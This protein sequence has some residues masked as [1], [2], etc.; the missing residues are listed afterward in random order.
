MV[1]SY[2]SA[3]LYLDATFV[4]EVHTAA[5]NHAA[6]LPKS[7]PFLPNAYPSPQ[8]PANV[9]FGTLLNFPFSITC[10]GLPFFRVARATPRFSPRAS[11]QLYEQTT[12]QNPSPKALRFSPLVLHRHS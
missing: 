9:N 2:L 8:R 6:R 7:F 10:S 3:A 11:S 4:T 1:R 5:H 12:R